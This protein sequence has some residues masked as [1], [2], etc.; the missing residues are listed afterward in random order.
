MKKLATLFSF[1]IFCSTLVLCSSVF[2]SPSIV[3]SQEVT[4][5][6]ENEF[7]FEPLQWRFTI[8]QGWVKRTTKEIDTTRKKGKKALEKSL[9]GEIDIDT[10][11]QL[12][13]LKKG[14]ANFFT[15][16]VEPHTLV[17]ADVYAAEQE[18]M[19]NALLKSYA[20]N[21][22]KATGVRGKEVI[23]GVEFSTLAV[24][25]FSKKDSSVLVAKARYFDA[26]F[27]SYTL[28]LSYTCTSEDQRREIASAIKNSRFKQAST[29]LGS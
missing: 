14:A 4:Q 13:Y 24:S 3:C 23:D 10:S 19:F 17:E 2:V 6:Q 21:G 8:P 22:I 1:P 9:E 12:L 20:D 11:K 18:A 7:F 16:D 5:S 15:S 25:F 26:Q 29:Q 27:E 28:L